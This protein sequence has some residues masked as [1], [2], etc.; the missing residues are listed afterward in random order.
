M[1]TLGWPSSE[2]IKA[3]AS[4]FADSILDSCV[5][6][7]YE[8]KKASEATTSEK[9]NQ[10]A[11]AAAD[12]ALAAADAAPATAEVAYRGTSELPPPAPRAPRE[13]LPEEELRRR[14]RERFSTLVEE[15]VL[16]DVVDLLFRLM[17]FNKYHRYT[18]TVHTALSTRICA[19]SLVISFTSRIYPSLIPLSH[20]P[21]IYPSLTPLLP[22]SYPSPTPRAPAAACLCRINAQ[23]GLEHPYCAQFRDPETEALA[24]SRVAIPINDNTKKTTQHYR[25]ACYEPA[26]LETAV[27]DLRQQLLSR[28]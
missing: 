21:L 18:Y 1:E 10:A 15:A 17:L 25:D 16:D 7:Q 11:P 28:I 23:A 8:A 27:K 6:S 14:W 12:A 20:T 2:D 24:S 9:P 3:V 26:T 13:P 5:V 19:L 22:L 4:P